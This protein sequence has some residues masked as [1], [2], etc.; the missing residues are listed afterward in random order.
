MSKH[1]VEEDFNHEWVNPIFLEN[2]VDFVAYEQ[3]PCDDDRL[4]NCEFNS[5]SDEEVSLKN[6]EMRNKYSFIKN[7]GKTKKKIH[8]KLKEDPYMSE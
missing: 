8:N 2:D 6:E 3:L 5:S 1:K 7:N 4:N